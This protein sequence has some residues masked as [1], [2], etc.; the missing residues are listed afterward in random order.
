MPYKRDTFKLELEEFA[1]ALRDKAMQNLGAYRNV[2]GKRRRAVATDTLRK[3]LSYKITESKGKMVLSLG[4]TGKAQQY[5]DFV[6]Q[7]VNGTQKNVGSPY[8]FKGGSSGG[9]N[10]KQRKKGGAKKMGKMQKAI[11]DWMEAKPVRLRTASGKMKK[12]TDAD[13]RGVAFLISKKI[14]AEGLQPV[15]Y[16]RDAYEMIIDE[17]E[18]RFIK[19][20]R[21]DVVLSYNEIANKLNKK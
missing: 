19:A 8:S 3:S 16:M 6:E 9:G 13:K 2:K 14:R 21:K 1:N 17:Y 20:L 7:G 10:K 5:A 4:A 12:V 15:H 11:Y 18:Q